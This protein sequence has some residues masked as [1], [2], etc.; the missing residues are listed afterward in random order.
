[1]EGEAGPL[2]AATH[3]P[4]GA[5]AEQQFGVRKGTGND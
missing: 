2:E 1:M 5:H 4:T 3:H